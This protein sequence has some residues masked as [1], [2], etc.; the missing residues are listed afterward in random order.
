MI[1]MKKMSDLSSV[2]RG[3]SLELEHYLH[4]AREATRAGAETSRVLNL[5]I[6]PVSPP[7]IVQS[8]I[9]LRNSAVPLATRRRS[10]KRVAPPVKKAP[11]V[12][13]ASFSDEAVS[14]IKESVITFR[15][16][17]EQSKVFTSTI[18]F[19][20]GASE[21]QFVK[22]SQVSGIFDS[23]SLH[24]F[25]KVVPAAGGDETVEEDTPGSILILSDKAGARALGREIVNYVTSVPKK[26]MIV[27]L[28]GCK[29]V[30]DELKIDKSVTFIG[31]PGSTIVVNGGPIAIHHPEEGDG[32]VNTVQFA[33]TTII[34]KRGSSR[35]NMKP[36]A[37]AL[38][39]VWNNAEL[40]MVDCT[41]KCE[42][43]VDTSTVG[44][45]VFARTDG[46]AGGCVQA[47]ACG[48]SGF[49]AHI[50]CGEEGKVHAE[51]CSFV[52]S[53][54]SAVY[55]TN[56]TE[57]CVAG[58]TFMGAGCAGVDVRWVYRAM[59]EGQ[60]QEQKEK[61]EERQ[62]ERKKERR[63]IYVHDNVIH[64]AKDSGIAI[65]SS[66]PVSLEVAE[67]N[68]ELAGLSIRISNNTISNCV[69][70]G[71]QLGDVVLYEDLHI[72]GNKIYTVAGNGIS[73]VSCSR[74]T[75]PLLTSSET[76]P[77]EIS[78][79]SV[80]NCEANGIRLEDTCGFKI[81][82]CSFTAN[83]GRG[84]LLLQIHPNFTVSD[85]NHENGDLNLAALLREIS[86]SENKSDGLAVLDS[87]ASSILIKDCIL[88][89]N[90]MCGAL[91]NTENPSGAPEKKQQK[92]LS[93]RRCST[94][95]TVASESERRTGVCTG[96]ITFEKGRIERNRTGGVSVFNQ[97]LYF[98]GT[99][100]TFND[101]F[102]L[103]INSYK[104]NVKYSHDTLAGKL[105]QGK[106]LVMS[107][108][109]N[110]YSKKVP[111]DVCPCTIM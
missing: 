8:Q 91:I 13:R 101:D 5:R 24:D 66:E 106:V 105:I 23:F 57:V 89:S 30:L 96:I 50:M 65:Y 9:M 27:R 1:G 79:N 61:H 21:L 2:P 81:A 19:T 34:C 44:V 76:Y 54:N 92:E 62:E 11:S 69:H 42:C 26:H 37:N 25:S 7:E 12:R 103:S 85:K 20:S 63:E 32:R 3:F 72:V 97:N 47:T 90:D 36:E 38:F 22:N 82:H 4:F 6:L 51:K 33:Q 56:P 74:V 107:H 31:C 80:W 15:P 109:T 41:L 108:E 29:V 93:L 39:E 53:K 71:I 83:C 40:V 45:L 68:K 73:I 110:I 75:E 87:A 100:V 58:S 78:K 46:S 52:D 14:V 55:A 104:T 35:R 102:E 70:E 84:L 98:E 18:R 60:K 17:S 49:F 64:D 77:I 16:P 94:A 28:P 88:K 95:L 86:C 10:S 67:L 99:L 43:G 48:F 59:K 111:D